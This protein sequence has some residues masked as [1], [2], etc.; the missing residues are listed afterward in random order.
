VGA[1][2]VLHEIVAQMLDSLNPEAVGRLVDPLALGGAPVPQ[3]LMDLRAQ[4]ALLREALLLRY[5]KELADLDR[6]I[7]ALPP[8]TAHRYLA[9]PA[10]RKSVEMVNQL[11][12]HLVR[13]Y[14]QVA[15]L[16]DREE[17]FRVP[18]L[19]AVSRGVC[20][21]LSK[22][23]PARRQ[24]G[25]LS[26]IP[27]HRLR[28]ED[29]VQAPPGTLLNQISSWIE[30]VPAS[31]R[32]LVEPRAEANRLFLEILYGT[33]DLLDH[34]LNHES[35]PLRG[36][37]GRVLLAGEADKA[38]RAEI[39][40]DRSPLRVQLRRDF[41]QVDNLT[42]LHSKNEY[43]RLVP[44][45]FRQEKLAGR[46]LALLLAD[47][48]RFKAVNDALGHDFGDTLLSLAGRAVL[49]CCREEDPATRFGGDELLVVLRGGADAGARLAARIRGTFE[50]FKAGPI[51]SRLADLARRQT[52]LAGVTVGTLSI[53]VAQGLGRAHPRPCPNEQSLFRRADRMLYLAKG[54]GG[55]RTV[56]LVDALGLPLTGEE[57]DDYLGGPAGASPAAQP[58]PPDPRA[59]LLRRQA[60]GPALAF[61]GRTYEELVAEEQAP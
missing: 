43:L 15:L 56:V 50:E 35:S 39:Q 53:G 24:L 55:N 31:E 36:L 37:G 5:L 7:S 51:A 45:L 21:L 8:E 6:Q 26:P 29:L 9:S 23:V 44:I 33:A 47:L 25:A 18:P 14:G 34:L 12:N 3:R 46:E 42:G 38:I 58:P 49:S 2:L 52:G 10:G 60:Q 61:A 17:L 13:G 19:Y 22:L 28:A 54:L 40:Q 41:E 27:Q 30:A 48:D 57:H 16:I 20:E 1:V 11:R 4:W 59:F 32:L